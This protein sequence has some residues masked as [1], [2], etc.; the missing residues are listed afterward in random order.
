MEIV[1]LCTAR[2]CR[3]PRH[4]QDRFN[5]KMLLALHSSYPPRSIAGMLWGNPCSSHAVQ[6]PHDHEAQY[7]A[8]SPEPRISTMTSCSPSLRSSP[9]SSTSPSIAFQ[10]PPAS[11]SW[12]A[13][14]PYIQYNAD[15]LNHSSSGVCFIEAKRKISGV[16][17]V[18]EHEPSR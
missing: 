7:R 10:K 18:V 16:F 11:C 14:Y 17:Q 8:K 2:Q 5:F 6:E 12:R 4:P 1:R 13:M 9:T 3:L 15:L